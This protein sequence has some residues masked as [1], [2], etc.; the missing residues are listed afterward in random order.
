[1]DIW[2]EYLLVLFEETRN[3]RLSLLLHVVIV[4]A[5][6]GIHNLTNRLLLAHTVQVLDWLDVDLAGPRSKG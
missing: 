6:V 2:E 3:V 1:M 4:S 5:T